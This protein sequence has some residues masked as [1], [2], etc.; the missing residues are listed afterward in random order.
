LYIAAK[1]NCEEALANEVLAEIT[2]GK[3][4]NL[5]QLQNKYHCK[6]TS[7]PMVHVEQHLLSSYNSLIAMEVDY[8]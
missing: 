5:N 6:K 2:M 8:A 3:R 7:S 4:P 1:Q